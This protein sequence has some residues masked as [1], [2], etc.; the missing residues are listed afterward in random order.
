[1]MFLAIYEKL[2]NPHASEII[3]RDFN[4]TS[5]FPASPEMWI[6]GAGIVEFIIGA[7]LVLGWYTRLSSAIAFAVLSLSFFYFGEE[8]SSHIMLFGTL[9]VLYITR[10]G[11]WSIDCKRENVNNEFTC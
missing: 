2:L 3:V 6:L 11:S 9:S 10:G 1:M 4:L 8:V 7:M 5:V